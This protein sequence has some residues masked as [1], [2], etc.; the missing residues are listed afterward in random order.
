MADTMISF[1]NNNLTNEFL[2]EED[3]RKTCPFAFMS[4]PSNP[5]VSDKYVQATTI[6]VVHDM[7][8]LGWYPVVAKQCRMKKNT[9]GIRSFHMLAF[10]N[11]DVKILNNGTGDIEGFPRI[12]LSNSHDGFNSFKFMCG[13]YRLICSN[14][15]VLADE[16]FAKMSIRHINYSFEELRTMVASFVESLPNKI[17]VLNDMRNTVLTDEEKTKFA[18]EAIKMRKGYTEEDKV[19]ISEETIND[20]LEPVRNEDK[21]NTL[22]NVYN[23]IQEKLIKGNFNYLE[24]NSKKKSRKMRKITGIVKDLQVNTNLFNLA[25]SY[26]KMAA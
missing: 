21:G 15:L 4:N 1:A 23:V 17:K 10:Q 8:K 6:D 19:E 26:L 24:K 18:T 5:D 2:T 20:V 22:W 11:P 9:K 16:E 13:F 14:G 3:I 12:I 25:N 7:A